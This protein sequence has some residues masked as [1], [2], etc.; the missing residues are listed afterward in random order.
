MPGMMATL[1]N[2]GINEEIVESMARSSGEAWFAWDKLP[3][4]HPVPGACPSACS[5]KSSARS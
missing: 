2:V 1:L 4:V 3:K 5:G